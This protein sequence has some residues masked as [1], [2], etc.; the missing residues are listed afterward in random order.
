MIDA[1]GGSWGTPSAW[2]NSWEAGE[3]A[4]V[5]Y[6]E[7]QVREAPAISR[8]R[9]AKLTREQGV[10]SRVRVRKVEDEN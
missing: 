5:T 10:P 2:G 1:W 4:V 9:R 6:S 7:V 8:S 3:V